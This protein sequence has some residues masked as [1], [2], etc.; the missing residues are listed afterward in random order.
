M[1]FISSLILFAI[2]AYGG[3]WMWNNNSALQRF[4][5]QK[6]DS[7]KFRTIEERF[8]AEQIMTL[9]SAELLKDESHSYLEP[10]L[11][12]HPYLIMEVKYIMKD[13][14]ITG[15]GTILWGQEDGEMVIDTKTWEKTHGFEDAINAG[16]DRNDF[17][18]IN[19]ISERGGT[20]SREDLA[21]EL[22]TNSDVLDAWLDSVRR[23][24]LVLRN[25]N[26]Y[27]L[28]FHK[29]RFNI[30]PVTKMDSWIVTKPYKG[31]NRVPRK[32]TKSQ[33]ARISKAAFGN[34][35]TIRTIS[36][37]FLPIHSIKVQNPDGSVMT[38]HWN[39]VNGKRI[40]GGY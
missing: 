4:V 19:A 35:F 23:K 14:N 12:F 8:S 21:Q 15:E 33:I 20:M 7:G 10:A 16:A 34:H 28:H 24:Q 9:H 36:E 38:S 32:Y 3:W 26:E 27:K 1:R 25:K 39:A 17:R 13:S 2:I 11:L 22:H 40:S 29:P 30:L 5:Q 31:A 18:V 37:V 6:L